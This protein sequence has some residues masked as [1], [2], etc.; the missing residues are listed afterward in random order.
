MGIKCCSESN[1]RKRNKFDN[2]IYDSKDK[3]R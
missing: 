3:I 1:N 2:N